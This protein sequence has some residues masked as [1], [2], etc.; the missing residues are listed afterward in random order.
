MQWRSG[1]GDRE[2]VRAPLLSV[3]AVSARGVL[4]WVSGVGVQLG[5]GRGGRLGHS[6]PSW[7]GR[8]P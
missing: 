1:E 3:K 5:S 8:P 7:P 6:V 4:G 2:V